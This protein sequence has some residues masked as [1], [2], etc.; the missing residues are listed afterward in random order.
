MKRTAIL[1]VLLALLLAP[2][3]AAYAGADPSFLAS[4]LLK[5][6]GLAV[7]LSD[8]T[9]LPATGI[10][11]RLTTASSAAERLAA[12][13]NFP[14]ERLVTAP[15]QRVLANAARVEPLAEALLAG[16]QA[17]FI[18][19]PMVVSAITDGNG[20]VIAVDL[21]NAHEQAVA[22][23]RAGKRTLDQLPKK[24]L[25]ILVDGADSRGAVSQ[26]EVSAAGVE[27]ESMAGFRVAE[28]TTGPAA[29]AVAGSLSNFE[30][31][32]RTT[33]G[34]LLKT[35]QRAGARVGVYYGTFDPVHEGHVRLLR[36]AVDRHGL[37]E[38][39]VIPNLYNPRKPGAVSGE[40]R[41]RMLA[42]R[43][44][45][46][47]GVNLY[48]GDTQVYES[49]WR[50]D[51]V[52]ERIRQTYGTR[53]LHQLVGEDRYGQMLADGEISAELDRG[54]IVFPREG[55]AATRDLPQGIRDRVTFS[56]HL[57]ADS[58]SSTTIRN[59]IRAGEPVPSEELD[60][61]LQLYIQF[62]GLYR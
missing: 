25:R 24:R 20:R 9:S 14:I 22:A 23:L 6:L 10:L 7:E 27:L 26:R 2:I 16:R 59:R 38:V 19:H 17:D 44:R 60:A 51:P 35:T 42:L 52:F 34:Q 1:K 62:H 48:M 32:S 47:A 13:R 3:G 30:L 36:S 39:V 15:G 28:R 61:E 45:R 8:L 21:W 50:R 37:D 54:L 31:G 18:S 29:I 33:V 41:L 49:V 40:H 55:A 53:D 5:P 11:R 58:L 57:D 46:E 56:D 43:L 4:K 12:L